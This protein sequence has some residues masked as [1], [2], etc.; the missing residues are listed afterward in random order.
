MEMQ[1]GVRLGSGLLCI[2]ADL[3][4]DDSPYKASILDI[5]NWMKTV[6]DVDWK[7]PGDTFGAEA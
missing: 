7:D 6:L 2:L 5:G 1:Q 4:S 3:P